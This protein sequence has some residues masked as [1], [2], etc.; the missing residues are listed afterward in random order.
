MNG[1]S[2]SGQKADQNLQI[3]V[4]FKPEVKNYK[5]YFFY[6]CPFDTIK[7]FLEIS[8]PGCS[9]LRLNVLI[10]QVSKFI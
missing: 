8:K 3:E 5:L 10:V 9:R 4:E 6:S 2:V 7:Y 1:L